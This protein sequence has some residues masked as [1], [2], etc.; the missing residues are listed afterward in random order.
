MA[1]AQLAALLLLLLFVIGCGGGGATDEARTGAI[2]VDR[3]SPNAGIYRV[4]RD[5]SHLRRLTKGTARA[6]DLEPDWSPDG[7]SIAF[8]R[9][10]PAGGRC[11]IYVMDAAGGDV[12]E[13]AGARGYGP[14]WSPDGKRLAFNATSG[15]IAIVSADGGGLRTL[16]SVGSRKPAWS[17]DGRRIAY[18][19]AV[20][21][22]V[23][24]IDGGRQ[25]SLGVGLSPKSGLTW[26]PDGRRL[27]FVDLRNATTSRL[28]LIRPNGAGR[29][30]VRLPRGFMPELESNLDWSPDS[31]SLVLAAVWDPQPGP[32]IYVVPASGGRPRAVV[33]GRYGDPSWQPMP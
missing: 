24:E 2:A 8:S 6:T 9:C 10:P 32:G 23:V 18:A 20:D 11:A 22:F 3:V 31:R 4:E 1:R 28:T 26:S 33:I 30:V 5:G 19:T 7:R 14:T 16:T 15:G 27:A 21:V 17:P 12:H 29:R 25:R 13:F